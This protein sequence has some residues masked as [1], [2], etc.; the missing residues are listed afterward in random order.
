VRHRLARERS[1]ARR[2][3]KCLGVIAVLSGDRPFGGFTMRRRFTVVFALFIGAIAGITALPLV[4]E[5]KGLLDEQI[6]VTKGISKN[7]K[8]K[9]KK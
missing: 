5:K 1:F 7:I 4:S 6:K 9:G 8:Y 2:P 3:S